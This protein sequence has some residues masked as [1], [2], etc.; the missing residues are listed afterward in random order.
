MKKT[1]T[2]AT[3]LGFIAVPSFA[4][5]FDPDVSTGNIVP[6]VAN[7]GSASAYAQATDNYERGYVRA[8]TSRKIHRPAYRSEHNP[9]MIYNENSN[10]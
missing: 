6:P 9:K 8:Q 2:I 5:S 10:D 3:F 4:Q 1:L 7:Q